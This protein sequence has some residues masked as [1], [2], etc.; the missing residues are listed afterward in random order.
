MVDVRITIML[1]N[2]EKSEHN[3]ELIKQAEAYCLTL[4][5]VKSEFFPEGLEMN[6][7]FYIDEAVEDFLV[8]KEIKRNINK[9]E[10]DCLKKICI[11]SQKELDGFKSGKTT[12]FGWRMIGWKRPIA[13]VP[14]E[15]IVSQLPA[16]IKNLRGDEIIYNKNLP[17]IFI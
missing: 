6:L 8:Q 12:K 13:E 5:R 2:K 14:T 9:L 1:K 17:K 7:E 10:K 16:I 15:I 3:R 11:V 4:P